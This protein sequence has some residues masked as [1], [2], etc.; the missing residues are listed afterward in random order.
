M[1]Y[2][3]AAAKLRLPHL[4]RWGFLL[5]T[6]SPTHKNYLAVALHG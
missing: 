2:N 4:K 6:I 1:S 5:Q 3:F